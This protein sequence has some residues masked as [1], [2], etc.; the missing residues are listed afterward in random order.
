[1]GAKPRAYTVAA[2]LPQDIDEAWIASFAETLGREQAQFGICL[3][4]GDT[5]STPGP[6]SLTVTAIG[7]V[8][9]TEALH[10]TGA[11]PGDHIWV[12]GTIGDAFVGL[13]AVLGANP[14]LDDVDA[15]FVSE[16]YHRPTPRLSLG[17]ALVGV[18]NA[19]A[20]V[21]DGLIADLGHI[22]GASEL[23]AVIEIDAIPLSQ[24]AR[25]A[26]TLS[27]VLTLDA[28]IR[29]GDDYELVFTAPAD[30]DD[31]VLLAAQ[32]S[33]T[34]VTLI[35]HMTQGNAGVIV[36]QKGQTLNRETSGYR[37]F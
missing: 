35:G 4:G 21:S 36:D 31:A 37:H 9:R 8:S 29:G 7:T 30:C 15:T 34:P 24:A 20:D 33:S 14:C 28:L 3:V 5:V 1:M 12:S 26:M 23:G 18:A 16:R 32:R 22:C 25:N 13:Q 10:R 27:P 17:M 11:H 6:L 19:A 2:A